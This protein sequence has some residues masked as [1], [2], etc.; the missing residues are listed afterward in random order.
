M[1]KRWS[2][3]NLK[4]QVFLDQG[5]IDSAYV[6]AKKAFYGLPKNALHATTFAQ[7]LGIKKTWMNS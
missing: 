6:N 1:Q 2:L 3:E 4:A 5:K 7:V